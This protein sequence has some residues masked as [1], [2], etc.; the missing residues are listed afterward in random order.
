MTDILKIDFNVDDRWSDLSAFFDKFCPW[1]NDGR[2]ADSLLDLSSCSYLGPYAASSI[3]AVW[4]SMKNQGKPFDVKLPSGPP[5]LKAFCKF[6]GLDHYLHK[7][8]RPNEDHPDCETVPLRVSYSPRADTGSPLIKLLNRHIQL[9]SESEE[10]LRLCLQEVTQNIADHSES[11]FGGV[12]CGRFFRKTNEVRIACVDC[13]VGI[14]G[15]LERRHTDIRSSSDALE[16]VFKG[17][18]SS[19]SRE[20]NMGLG[21]SHLVNWV[22]TMNGSLAV[23]SDNGVGLADVDSELTVFHDLPFHFGGTGVFFTVS[24]NE[25]QAQ[26]SDE[27]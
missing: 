7:G 27:Y 17:G 3:Y 2:G 13:G 10:Y 5:P 24:V 26:P 11:S 4:A 19:Q 23:L 1:I 16:R 20:N 25:D 18:F 9:S 12:W 14:R 8:S 15:S 6:S 21:I 22:R